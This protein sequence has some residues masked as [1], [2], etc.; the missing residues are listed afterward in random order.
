MGRPGAV[1]GDLVPRSPCTLSPEH[2]HLLLLKALPEA[3]ITES[4]HIQA[5]SLLSPP[6]VY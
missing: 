3:L 5:P 4:S 6:S 1:L 2:S